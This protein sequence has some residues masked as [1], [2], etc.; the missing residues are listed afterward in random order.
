MS[1]KPL[2]SGVLGVSS[3]SIK[4]SSSNL[5]LYDFTNATSNYEES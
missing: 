4:Q 3:P 2:K 1:K 5:G